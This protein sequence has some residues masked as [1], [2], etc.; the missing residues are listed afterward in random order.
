MVSRTNP[1]ALLEQLGREPGRTSALGATRTPQSPEA[2]Y[3]GAK[4]AGVWLVQP[5]LAI[6]GGG[7][8]EV[9]AAA[10]AAAVAVAAQSRSRSRP[11]GWRSIVSDTRVGGPRHLHGSGQQA[12]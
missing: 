6:D 4:C 12:G 9:V 2:R 8:C 11:P 3:A 1:Q 5:S 10:A 7:G